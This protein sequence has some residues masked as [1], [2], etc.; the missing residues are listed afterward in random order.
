MHVKERKKEKKRSRGWFKKKRPV[1]YLRQYRESVRGGRTRTRDHSVS[2]KHFYIFFFKNTK[3]FTLFLFFEGSPWPDP[4]QEKAELAVAYS[5]DAV[6]PRLVWC[7][8]SLHTSR[9][10]DEC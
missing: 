2:E 5:G 3:N 4:E 6:R 7:V 8:V 1:E 10:Q 9:R